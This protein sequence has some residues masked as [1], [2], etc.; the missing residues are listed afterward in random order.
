QNIAGTVAN[1]TLNLPKSREA[2]TEADRIGVELAARAG[3]DPN[4]AIS[5][6]EKMAKLSSSQP[7][8][9]LSTHPAHQDRIADLRNYAARVMP[10]Y[11]AAKGSAAAGK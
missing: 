5:L 1:V 4:A 7:P 3:Y 8:K 10:L 2:E 11:T 6:W 9:W